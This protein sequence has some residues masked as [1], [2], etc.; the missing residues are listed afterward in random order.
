MTAAQRKTLIDLLRAGFSVAEARRTVSL[1]KKELDQ[2]LTENAGFKREI[3]DAI[4]HGKK[5]AQG[6]ERAAPSADQLGKTSAGAADVSKQVP[7][8]GDDGRVFM[9][10]VPASRGEDRPT[11]T[12][13]SDRRDRILAEAIALTPDAPELYQYYRWVE[14]RCV[15]AG[16]HEMSE[17]WDA[18]ALAFYAS[19]KK[20]DVGRA[21]LRAAKSD[22]VCRLVVAESLFATRLLE[23]GLIGVCPVIAQRQSEASDRFNTISQI[24]RACGLQEVQRAAKLGVDTFQRAGGGASALTIS[25]QDLQEHPIE[26]RIYA[27]T[28]SGA[29]GFTGISGFCDEVDLWG[30]DKGANPAERVIELLLTRFTTQPGAKLH[31]MS[32]SY[33]QDSY[34]AKMVAKGDTALQRVMRLGEIGAAKDFA[35]RQALFEFLK[36]N[37]A[38]LAKNPRAEALLSVPGDPNAVDIPAWASNPVASIES[39]YALAKENIEHMLQ[40]YGGRVRQG[41]ATLSGIEGLIEA[42]QRLANLET[43]TRDLMKFESITDRLDPRSPWHGAKR[44]ETL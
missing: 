1:Q 2:V 35:A 43:G 29:V 42:N 25:L 26:F 27:A 9:V 39:C 40:L 32:A 30:Q 37:P 13:S 21:G 5:R 44:G 11:V 36:K 23:P 12:E 3:D 19:G 17:V 31:L 16:L 34:H 10:S 41:G 8:A 22:S 14:R 20:V 24:I 15:R 33:R 28:M 38:E 18:H 7:P 4:A 6:T